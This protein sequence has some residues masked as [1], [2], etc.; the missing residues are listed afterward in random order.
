MAKKWVSILF[1]ICGL[2]TGC[3]SYQELNQ[4]GIVIAMGLDYI[5]EKDLY[6][7]TF[8]VINPSE[9]SSQNPGT[10]GT[11]VI[12]YSD[13]GKTLSEAARNSTKK[14][15][16]QNVYSQVAL[17][18]VGE[19]LA[20]KKGLNFIFDTFE[21]DARVRVNI[22][23]LIARGTK[24]E[25]VL[26][27]MPAL[28][29]IPA[30]SIISKLKNTSTVLGEHKNVRLYEVVSQLGSKGKEPSISGISV[31]GN[32]EL[33][34]SKGNTEQS[35]NAY[36]Y[37]NG[38]GMLRNGK[39][40]GW[41]DGKKS[42]AIQVI[43]NSIKETNLTIKCADDR[44]NSIELTRLK[45]SS[46]VDVKSGKASINIKLY[47]YGYLDELLCNKK[48]GREK[49]MEK[50]QKEAA[51]ELKKEVLSGIKAAQKAKSDIFGF[52][53]MYHM[54]HPEKWNSA[55]KNWNQL[56]A[57]ASVKINVVFRLRHTGMNVETYPY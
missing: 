8:Q 7:V 49:V 19:D 36:T 22:P 42:K 25:D 23:V 20:T 24:V 30:E 55:K 51:Q 21:R 9:N 3:S 33:G 10:G 14:F 56:F 6:K 35:K 34:S 53:E 29:K 31:K 52:G 12:G 50:F 54:S 18:L 40:V 17:V 15:S 4:L 26:D 45:S 5:P 13:T 28:D 44:Y 39:L 57:N 37:L 16:R 27:I 48:I 32:I 11:P 2:V 43:D 41:L 38:V 1:L 46:K 47:G